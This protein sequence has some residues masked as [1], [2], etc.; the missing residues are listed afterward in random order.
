MNEQKDNGISAILGNPGEFIRQLCEDRHPCLRGRAL[1]LMALGGAA[2]FGFGIGYFVDWKVALLDSA[3]MC[4]VVL[5]AYLLCLPSLYVFA[6]ISGSKVG[7]IQLVNIGLVVLSGIGCI[8]AALSPVLWLFAVS[9]ESAPMFFILTL[10]LA[11]VAVGLGVRTIE[12]AQKSGTVSNTTGLSAW[13]VVFLVV[14]LQAITLVR[15]MLS[16]IGTSPRP[17]GKCFF[18][19]H[20]YHCFC[21]AK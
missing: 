2:L 10:A 15:P 5:F 14:V 13:F 19:S 11:G 21:D 6:S 1:L 18:V 7:F 3:K 9:T 20:F 16:P 8:L 12:G 17:A 4:G